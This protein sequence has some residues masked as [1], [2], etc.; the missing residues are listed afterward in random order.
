MSL[1]KRIFKFIGLVLLVLVLNL[2]PMI[3]IGNQD[4]TPVSL[5]W[6]F[7]IL[8]LIV[9]FLIIW[10]IWKAYVEKESYMITGR[11]FTW[12][13]FGMALLFF[14]ATRVVAVFGTLLLQKVTGN[15]MSANDAAL[16]ATASDLKHMFPMYFVA[17]HVMIAIFAPV[18][19][20]LTFRGFFSRY[21]FK[22]DNM[23]A[24]CL[25]SSLIFAL[26]HAVMPLEIIIYLALGSIFFFAFNRE[27]NIR[28]SIVVHMLN[29]GL[30]VLVSVVN[31][32][33]LLIGVI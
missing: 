10:Q 22:E 26:L 20:E 17:F 3:L 16:Q 1:V 13:R 33:L 18:L 8:Y 23:W 5:Q 28:D 9:A 6:L 15:M 4:K 11:P 25:V 31:Y 2:T 7:S 19:E 29:N 14:L 30:I 32:I 24:K 21:F 12:E 27:G